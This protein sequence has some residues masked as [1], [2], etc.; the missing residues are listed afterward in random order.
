MSQYCLASQRTKWSCSTRN[1]HIGSR[2]ILSLVRWPTGSWYLWITGP[3]SASRDI[4]VIRRNIFSNP[5]TSLSCGCANGVGFFMTWTGRI[6]SYRTVCSPYGGLLHCRI[7]GRGPQGLSAQVRGVPL[8]I[9]VLAG[10]KTPFEKTDFLLFPNL[11]MWVDGRLACLEWL[12][13]EIS[14][15]N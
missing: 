12:D 6:Q 8:W 13:L 10:P 1:T 2:G 14:K 7:V 5:S 3:Y 11:S 4:N 9:W 15:G